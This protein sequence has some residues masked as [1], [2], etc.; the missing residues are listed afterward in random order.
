MRQAQIGLRLGL[1]VDKAEKDY[2]NQ[3]KT[4]KITSQLS[5][6]GEA[7]LWQV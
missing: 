2:E 1:R 5:G 7:G 6:L 3:G 4:I